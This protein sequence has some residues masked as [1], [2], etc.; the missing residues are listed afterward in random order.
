M[1]DDPSLANPSSTLFFCKNETKIFT[2]G[3]TQVILE[4][5]SGSQEVSAKQIQE[6]TP[7]LFLIRAVYTLI[8]FLMSGFLFVFCVQLILSL[9][10][11]LLFE[12]GLTDNAE[13]FTVLVFVGILFSIPVFLF[14][15]ANMMTIAMAFIADTWN[16][17]KFMK[18]ILE[19]DNIL[20]R[21]SA[22]VY[23]FVSF[24]VGAIDGG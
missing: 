4:K 23:A 5:D 17:Q 16:G 1:V 11:G 3:Q 22:T 24:A 6:G 21:L 12:S 20:D 9:F 14:A 8:A 7:G 15:M 10:L 2:L 13:T 18:T 19:R